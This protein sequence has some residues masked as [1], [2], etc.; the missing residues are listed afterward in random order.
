MDLVP[1]ILTAEQPGLRP[2]V[3]IGAGSLCEF[4]KEDRYRNAYE[5]PRVDD[6]EVKPS[7][8]RELVDTL[9]FGEERSQYYF[10]SVSL[11]GTGC[12]F[13][14]EYCMVLKRE[15]SMDAKV[16]DRNSYDLL[17]P[18]LSLSE[19]RLGMVVALR[20]TWRDDIT[21]MLTAKVAPELP[22]EN[23]LTTPGQVS[24][25]VSRDEDFAEVHL[26]GT[27][28]TPRRAPS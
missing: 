5:R 27:F 28:V 15:R 2:V 26:R 9:L 6:V 13:Y 19:D 20:G 23:R 16:F 4:L 24:D 12:R 10:G 22:E 3:N 14:G 17:T 25:L 1:R 18:P 8:N 11:G 7:A 21:S